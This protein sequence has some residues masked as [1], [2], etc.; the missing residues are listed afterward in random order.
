[1]TWLIIGLALI[2]DIATF[3]MAGMGSPFLILWAG[4][5]GS[6]VVSASLAKVENDAPDNWEV[7]L[8]A[9]ALFLVYYA[10]LG[11]WD[12]FYA[13]PVIL[14]FFALAWCVI[15]FVYIGRP[16]WHIWPMSLIM[17]VLVCAFPGALLHAGLEYASHQTTDMMIICIF[18]SALASVAVIVVEI[19]GIEWLSD[20][21]LFFMNCN[22][23]GDVRFITRGDKLKFIV[24]N[25]DGVERGEDRRL[26][27][28][29][30]LERGEF[31]RI[32][33][34]KE[35][36]DIIDATVECVPFL[37]AMPGIY[38][39]PFLA[40]QRK[41]RHPF[42]KAPAADVDHGDEHEVEVDL[43]PAS[44]TLLWVADVDIRKETE[45][46]QGSREV[47]QTVGGEIRVSSPSAIF[48]SHHWEHNVDH[49]WEGLTSDIGRLQGPNIIGFQGPIAVLYAARPGFLETLLSIATTPV[50][51]TPG[52][53]RSFDTFVEVLSEVGITPADDHHILVKSQ[54][55]DE[56]VQA[57][58][59]AMTRARA[60]QVT[61]PLR[62]DTMRQ[63]QTAQV[64]AVVDAVNLANLEPAQRSAV[65]ERALTFV[66]LGNDSGLAQMM[67]S[68]GVMGAA[69]SAGR[70]AAAPPPAAGGGGGGGNRGGGGNPAGG[71]H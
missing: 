36:N 47:N 71:G 7:G 18:L 62:A 14:A 5:A 24:A 57:A 70:A 11:W 4:I 9:C 59:S 29:E 6:L 51:G 45:T 41:L 3:F 48:G 49:A 20:I 37:L 35:E 66:F 38:L 1:M 50:P 53:E 12:W 16:G 58:R 23:P 63:I 34:W 27:P 8:Q 13:H 54:D 33:E 39:I 64:A 28:R 10:P 32:R 67:S 31:A 22:K 26:P 68:M 46:G 60:E 43:D 52:L 15:P 19:K 69:F 61:A 2:L 21:G 65:L 44:C 40:K 17:G 55:E 42:L 56:V 30:W 25:R